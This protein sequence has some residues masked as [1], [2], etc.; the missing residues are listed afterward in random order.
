MSQ[1]CLVTNRRS[2]QLAALM[3]ILLVLLTDNIGECLS[4]NSQVLCLGRLILQVLLVAI[5]GAAVVYGQ[6]W[7]LDHHAV[8]GEVLR[9]F[10]RLALALLLTLRVECV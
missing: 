3:I 10:L 6:R 7:L 8:A 5:V 4:S 2:F 9:K 1:S